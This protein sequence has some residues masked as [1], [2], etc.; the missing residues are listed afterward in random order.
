MSR[1]VN[2]FAQV[3]QAG[4]QHGMDV[5]R[6][7]NGNSY[8][9]R[10]P[11]GWVA[12]VLVKNLMGLHASGIGNLDVEQGW[13]NFIN[14]AGLARFPWLAGN[15]KASQNSGA[16]PQNVTVIQG[17]HGPYAV[18]GVTNPL[19]KTA[20]GPGV[21]LEPISVS[22]LP[23]TIR[24]V[25]QDVNRLEGLGIKRIVVVSHMGEAAD[26]TLARQTA[27]IDVIVGTADWD[28]P[29]N[30]TVTSARGEPVT[31]VRNFRRGNTL[32]VSDVRFTPQGTVA[33]ENSVRIPSGV[34]GRS[35]A[36]DGVLNAA[37]GPAKPVAYLNNTIPLDWRRLN[38]VGLFVART[39]RDLSQADVALVRATEIRDDVTPGWL[40]DRKLSTLLPFEE[41][42]VMVSVSGAA[43][44]S[45][46]QRSAQGKAPLLHPAG[47]RYQIDAAGTPVGVTVQDRQTGRWGPL[48]PRRQYRVAMTGYPVVNN[49]EYPEF[50]G[51][52]VVWQS[53]LSARGMFETGVRQAGS[54]GRVID[55]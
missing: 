21:S 11:K 14:G 35:P 54:P 12:N 3:S 33:D 38:P 6:L 22:N 40:T 24:Q 7:D 25:Q 19:A 46:L 18:I 9:G 52:P 47:I 31:I 39:A 48:D 17:Q 4:H 1:L 26:D 28:R 45:A 29:V 5:V 20:V 13:Q 32:G 15:L 49:M 23:E 30:Q 2:G 37:L 50:Y 55:L 34:F 42:L 53:D 10:C 16:A 36:A 41:K 43:I 8:S 27:G 51:A 44:Y